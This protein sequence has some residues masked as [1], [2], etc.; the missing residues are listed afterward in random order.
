M[1]LINILLVDDHALFAKSLAIALEEYAEIEHFI[2][3]Q[4]TDDLPDLATRENIDI[5][6]MDI[7]LGK[8][9]K[10][11]GL[12]IARSL[13]KAI[14]HLKIIMLTGYDLP[15]YRHEAKKAGVSGFLNKNINPDK[16]FDSILAVYQGRS[17]FPAEE[18]E[19]VIEDLTRTEKSIL[20][21]IA[22]GKKRKDIAKELYISERTLSNH[23]PLLSIC[24]ISGSCT[25][26]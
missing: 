2:I 24:S 3:A 10:N 15:V 13:L 23:S 12:M 26:C 7:H 8:S 11:D 21:L 17:C 6:L 5:V 25:S 16:L 14:P 19:P 9:S 4:E 18:K 22:I 1:F 20:Q